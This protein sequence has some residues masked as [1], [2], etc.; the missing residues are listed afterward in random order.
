MSFPNLHVL[1]KVAFPGIF[2]KTNRRQGLRITQSGN[3][4]KSHFLLGS[5]GTT[6]VR[7]PSLGMA[8]S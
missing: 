5:E 2:R 6:K 8:P 7:S 3:L 1:L 4:P